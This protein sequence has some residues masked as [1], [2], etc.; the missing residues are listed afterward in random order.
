MKK[1]LFG[2]Q[3]WA[4]GPASKAE[5]IANGLKNEFDVYFCGVG[6]SLSFCKS[7]GTFN[8]CFELMIEDDYSDIDFKQFDC[9]ISVMDPFIALW[10]KK[11]NIKL[12][13]I[14]SMSWLWN[15]DK[16]EEIGLTYK[17]LENIGISGAFSIL[18]NMPPRSSKIVGQLFSDKVF[19][20][21]NYFK[22]NGQLKTTRYV[23]AIINNQLI[24]NNC[25]KN[26]VIISLSGQLCPVIDIGLAV[27]YSNLVTDILNDFIE[28]CKLKYR[29]V[30][31]G[32]SKVISKINRIPDVE[33]LSLKHTDFLEELNNARA[34]LCLCGFTTVYEA[35]AYNVPIM[36]LPENHEGH[37]Y[38]YK[39]IT[40]AAPDDIR[41]KIFPNLFL[42]ESDKDVNNLISSEDIMERLQVCYANILE[43]EE[44]LAKYKKRTT[45]FIHLFETTDIAIKQRDLIEKNIGGF[46]G[47]KEICESIKQDL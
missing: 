45:D 6:T 3:A 46:D 15:W 16:F 7:S 20:Q 30:V 8:D 22:D 12:Y 2:A 35:A 5:V 36:F 31:T 33:Y 14:D 29:V 38:E 17:A 19:V 34:I 13:W 39:L 41:V 44:L 47:I 23:S 11:N 24:D 18:K 9:V 32:N 1:I 40:K 10:A 42:D 21:G 27:R 28:Q 26:T 4:W 43:N 37:A 25:L